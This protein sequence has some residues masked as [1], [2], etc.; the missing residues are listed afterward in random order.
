LFVD[1]KDDRAAAFCARF[2]F[3]PTPGGPL[4]LFLPMETLSRL[5]KT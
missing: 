1:A 5:L 3:E 2:G 4:T